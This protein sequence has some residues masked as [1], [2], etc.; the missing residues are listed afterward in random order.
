[1]DLVKDN[2]VEKA[3]R[4]VSEALADGLQGNGVQP[5]GLGLIHVLGV[6]TGRRLFEVGL[7]AFLQRLFNQRIPVGHKQ[8]MAGLVGL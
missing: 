7:K 2:Q 3:G 6:N 8:N 1:M 4:K 5:V